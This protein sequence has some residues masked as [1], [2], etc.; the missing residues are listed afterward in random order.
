MVS[1][2]QVPYILFLVALGFVVPILLKVL[3]YGEPA[4]LFFILLMFIY[5]STVPLPDYFLWLYPL[6]VLLALTSGSKLSFGKKLLVQV[7]PCI[8]VCYS[9]V[10]LLV[11]VCRR[12]LSILLIRCCVRISFLLLLLR[13]M[14]S[15]C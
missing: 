13:I 7:Y 6:G 8:S 14:L 12:G 3:K 2:P 5:T 15:W 11:M 1:I 10:L 9:L 4:A